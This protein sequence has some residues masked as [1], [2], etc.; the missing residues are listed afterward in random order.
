MENVTM[1]EIL[2]DTLNRPHS[3]IRHV[4]DR[5]GHDRRYSLN[6]EKIRTL[7]WQ[8]QHSSAEAIQKTAEWYQNNEWWWRK[9]KSG[10]FKAYYQKQYGERLKASG[11]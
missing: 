8:P 7:G 2:L 9:I 5:P 3:L 6:V 11:D 1:V 10:D 4:K